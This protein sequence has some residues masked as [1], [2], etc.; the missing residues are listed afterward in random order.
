MRFPGC[1][2]PGRRNDQFLCSELE[3]IFPAP[4]FP[5]HIPNSTEYCWVVL[6]VCFLFTSPDCQPLESRGRVVDVS[7]SPVEW[8][9]TLA[10]VGVGGCVWIRRHSTLLR[11]HC[12]LT[13][14]GGA[15]GC[16]ATHLLWVLPAGTGLTFLFFELALVIHPKMLPGGFFLL[17]FWFVCFLFPLG[18]HQVTEQEFLFYLS[19]QLPRR[20]YRFPWFI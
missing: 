3:H 2:I 18:I 20:R 4:G 7:L 12:G 8:I 5:G 9:S 17:V 11:L 16:E 14:W 10:G 6:S 19:A 1:L 15:P 13:F